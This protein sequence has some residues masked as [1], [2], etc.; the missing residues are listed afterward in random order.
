M[1]I[2]AGTEVVGQQATVRWDTL[3]PSNPS[4]G[5]YKVTVEF[6]RT[7]NG[8]NWDHFDFLVANGTCGNDTEAGTAVMPLPSTLILLGSGLLGLAAFKKKS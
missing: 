3:L 4:T 8:G 2:A 6:P 1:V 5:L 7:V